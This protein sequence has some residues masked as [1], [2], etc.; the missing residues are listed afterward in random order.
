ML[1]T[2]EFVDNFRPSRR[3][4]VNVDSFCERWHRAYVGCI[5]DVSYTVNYISCP[6]LFS[7]CKEILSNLTGHFLLAWPGTSMMGE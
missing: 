6:E 2:I 3:F 1:N 5:S 4:S 7:I